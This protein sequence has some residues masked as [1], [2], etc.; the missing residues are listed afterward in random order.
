MREL[1]APLV[2][3]QRLFI[4]ILLILLVWAIWRTIAKKDFAVG[5]AL[6]LSLVVVVD[7]FMNTGIY[8][9]GL[10]R[11]SLRY[12]EAWALVLFC[13]R[14]K[15]QPH[16]A[17]HAA[18]LGLVGF[19]FLMI[20]LSVF[21]SQPLL[22]AVLEFRIK[23]IPQIVAFTLAIRGLRTADDFRRF[24][25]SLTALSILLGLFTFFDLF[26]DR[27]ILKSSMLENGIYVHNRNLNRFGSLFLN[28][29]YLGAFVVLVFPG[30]FV[31]ALNETRRW[32]R[33]CAWAALLLLVFALV[34]TQS[35]GPVLA[36]GVSLLALVI[37]P[38]GSVSR[39][40][41]V[42]FLA[43]CTLMFVLFMPGFLHHAFQ[44]FDQ[45]ETETSEGR[46]RETT[47]EY[48]LKMI[49][50]HPLAGIGFGEIEFTNTMIAYGFEREYGVKALDAPHN[51]YLQIAV[52]AGVPVLFVF[53]LANVILLGKSAAAS[54]GTAAHRDSGTIFGLAVGIFGFLASI[55]PDLQLFTPN[56]GPAYWMFFALLLSLATTAATPATASEQLAAALPRPGAPP[57]RFGTQRSRPIGRQAA[58]GERK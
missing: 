26:F 53:L 25:L 36:F 19:Y 22:S 52:Y 3:L 51:S 4:P 8:I 1:L 21:R 50:N 5:L 34:Q 49:A 16:Q 31:Y 35:R 20:F 11:G 41:R 30:L 13:T 2:H 12:S 37:G 48:A 40:R 32:R 38:C 23:I 44:R 15:G 54:L 45:I 18:V 28:P 9:P 6:Y 14:P 43:V 42:G 10:A 33:L 24:F 58:A 39:R 57:P 47:W 7:G 27:T 56:V 29:N 55:F 46:S 17:P